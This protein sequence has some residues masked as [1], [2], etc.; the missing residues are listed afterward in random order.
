MPLQ[1][2]AK[3]PLTKYLGTD[4]SALAKSIRGLTFLGYFHF[5]C[6]GFVSDPGPLTK[7]GLVI[8]A[9]EKSSKNHRL[10]HYHDFTGNVSKIT[11]TGATTLT[12]K[13]YPNSSPFFILG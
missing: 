9:R 5:A 4:D 3:P 2:S 8:R 11:F 13:P 12:H 10:F 6:F 1:S 7:K